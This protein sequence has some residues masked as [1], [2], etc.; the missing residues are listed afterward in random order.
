MFELDSNLD[1]DARAATA[2]RRRVGIGSVSEICWSGV[3][4]IS[5]LRTSP[6]DRTVKRNLTQF[7]A[8]RAAADTLRR[9]LPL[10]FARQQ[11]LPTTYA[12]HS[13]GNRMYSKVCAN[14]N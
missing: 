3:A 11:G 4:S 1:V 6:H 9:R 13:V 12:T 14:K 10:A 8:L 5:T 7:G 2:R